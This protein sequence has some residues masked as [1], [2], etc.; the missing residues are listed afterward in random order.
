ME[1]SFTNLMGPWGEKLSQLNLFG[2]FP[3]SHPSGKSICHFQGN[4][5]LMGDSVREVALVENH[6]F[7]TTYT[8]MF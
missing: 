8:T 2:F 3:F 7:A 5:A 6:K 4:Y 1:V